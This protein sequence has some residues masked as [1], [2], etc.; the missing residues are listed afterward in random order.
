MFRNESLE[1]VAFIPYVGTGSYNNNSVLG[2]TAMVT[3]AGEN[4]VIGANAQNAGLRFAGGTTTTLGNLYIIGGSAK[5]GY[6]T[7]AGGTV[8]QLTNKSTGVTLNKP[9][10]QITMNAAALAADTT[11]SFTLTNSV[12]AAGDILVL[13]NQAT[14]TLGAYTINGRTAA[15][16]AT[17]SVR[18]VTA[19]SLSEAMVISF[20]VIRAVTS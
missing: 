13:Q 3:T 19:G 18:N 10:G 14:G 1:G 4:L 15:G 2:D 12:I 9:T 8:T 5:L 6:D 20:A 17:I 16:S 11:V 7:G